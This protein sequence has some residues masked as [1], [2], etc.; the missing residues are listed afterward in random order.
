[1]TTT[2]LPLERP[3]A[4][5]VL[6]ILHFVVAAFAFLGAVAAFLFG[7]EVDGLPAVLAL[8]PA[9]IMVS[10]I[11]CGYGLWK[12]RPWGRI[13][14]IVLAILSLALVP[15]GTLIG[16]IILYV[17]FTKPVRL[18]YSGRDASTFSSEE[19]RFVEAGATSG[20]LILVAGAAVAAIGAVFMIGIIGAIAVPNLLSAID[21]GKQKRTMAD[22]RSIGVAIESYAVDHDVYPV[23]N[24]IEE[25]RP[26][27][28]PQY[29][30]Q[31]PLT[32]A[33]GNPLRVGSEAEGYWI[34][35]PAKDG[36]IQECNGG[37]TTSLEADI[38]FANGEFVQWPQGRQAD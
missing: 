20:M 27:V 35:S 23:V 37:P 13:L 28:E 2:V 7:G 1:M 16:V 6:A 4:I 3:P 36:G 21:R 34:V 26:L 14:Q 15:V 22:M 24:S 11:A 19:R 8:L 25:L 18:L 12:L 30:A 5:S 17:M 10:A 33:W 29:I 9:T 32:D 38:C 31:L